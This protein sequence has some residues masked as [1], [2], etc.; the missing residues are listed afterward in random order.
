MPES[1]VLPEL[2]LYL[3]SDG[4]AGHNTQLRGLEHG[5]S[6][7]FQIKV[8]R[9]DSE[10]GFWRCIQTLRRWR[11]Q[12]RS[13]NSLIVGAGGGTWRY[14]VIA[15]KYFGL[16]TLVLMKP[17]LWPY[18]W[19]DHI[20][21]PYH[22]DLREGK[23][24]LCTEGVLNPVLPATTADPTAGLILIGGPSKHHRWDENQ[25][26]RQIQYFVQTEK[27][28]RWQLTTSRRTPA[29]FLSNLNRLNLPRLTV[30]PID[31][32]PPNW[33]GEQ[34]QGVGAA[35]VTE[36]SMSMVFEC[37]SAGVQVGLISLPRRRQ[38]RVTRCIDGLINRG[39]VTPTALF[40]QKGE[41][42]KAIAPLQEASRVAGIL[43]PTLLSNG[44]S[45]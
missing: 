2:A 12:T 10:I 3:I 32:T 45:L 44:S 15:K 22:D 7:Y 18:S 24:I 6:Q 21:A 11:E 9:L 42:N 43:A 26:L 16:R 40:E 14:L 39:W 1:P 36:D 20:V 5:L 34:L 4:K 17:R 8:E 23:N 28:M 29:D 41:M 33:V 37:L 27:A 19:F 30:V 13:G 38:G 35:W 25:V 31:Q